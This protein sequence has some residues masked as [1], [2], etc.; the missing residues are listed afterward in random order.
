MFECLSRLRA[1]LLISAQV[2]LS[3]AGQ[4]TCWRLSPPSP[5]IPS[6][7]KKEGK[8]K[9]IVGDF[10][11]VV[12]YCS[13]LLWIYYKFM[14]FNFNIGV[15]YYLF[16]SAAYFSNPISIHLQEPGLAYSEAEFVAWEFENLLA[17]T[18]IRQNSSQ[19]ILAI[20]SSSPVSELHQLFF[21]FF[22]CCCSQTRAFCLFCCSEKKERS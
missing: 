5:S 17:I 16:Y 10:N 18:I 4:G 15:Q 11:I 20:W 9:W 7:P 14:F 12:F 22:F 13:F 1:W 6:P 2:M 3:G 19:K 21:F 8:K